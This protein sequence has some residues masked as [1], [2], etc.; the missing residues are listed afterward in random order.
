MQLDTP[1]IDC[2]SW[3]RGRAMVKLQEALYLSVDIN[4]IG[5]VWLNLWMVVHVGFPWVLQAFPATTI[6]AAVEQEKY[7]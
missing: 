2:M 7:S 5:E 3:S 4:Y 6:L 1:V